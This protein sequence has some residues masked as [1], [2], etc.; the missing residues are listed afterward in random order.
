MYLRRPAT[1]EDAMA[2]ISEFKN[3]EK[4]YGNFEEKPF[5]K[6]T[7]Q[8]NKQ[9]QKYNRQNFH[10]QNCSR[11]FPRQNYETQFQNQPNSSQNQQ[12]KKVWSSQ[13]VNVQPIQ[14]QNKKYLNNR[15]VYGPPKNVFKPNQ[16]AQSQL[17]TP[18]P[19]SRI[20]NNTSIRRS[21]YNNNNNYNNFR[22]N[23]NA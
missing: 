9:N 1:F 7:F 23:M 16:I 19:M 14:H 21:Y 17:P 20:S 6:K 8:P 15:Q 5:K 13:P 10:S 2:Y 22:Q 11:N 3:F 12:R 4:M 18:T